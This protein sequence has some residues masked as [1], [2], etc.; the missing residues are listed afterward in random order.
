M[1]PY[2]KYGNFMKRET[3]PQEIA[4]VASLPRND[5]GYGVYKLISP[6]RLVAK[7]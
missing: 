4:T 2:E 5:R 1:R 7:S 6:A 3:L